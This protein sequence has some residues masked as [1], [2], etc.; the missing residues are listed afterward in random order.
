MSEPKQSFEESFQKLEDIIR[1]LENDDVSLEESIEMYEEG[2]KLVSA[3]SEKLDTV[4]KRFK[5]LVKNG[6]NTA[7]GDSD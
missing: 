4:D 6:G 2:M 3:C 1:K 5:K 7:I